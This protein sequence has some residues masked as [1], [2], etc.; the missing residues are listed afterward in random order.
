VNDKRILQ[1]A[2]IGAGWW[3]NEAHLPAL[4]HNPHAEIAAIHS[5]TLDKARRVAHRFECAYAFDSVED[6]LAVPG[7]DA[8]V[9]SS[10]P[11]MHKE[12]ALAALHNRLHVV[13]EKPLTLNSP[14]A[15]LL[16]QEAAERNL[17]L[18]VS[19][20]WQFTRHA[21]ELK[22]RLREG[23]AGPLK[24]GNILMS[25]WM[26]DL[27]D[28]QSGRDIPSHRRFDEKPDPGSYSDPKVCGGGFSFTQLSHALSWFYEITEEAPIGVS[29]Q[30]STDGAPVDLFAS[31]LV[32]L[33]GDGL[34]TVSGVGDPPPSYRPFE[35]RLFHDRCAA[36]LELWKG[37]LAWVGNGEP[38]IDWPELS[39]E[40]RYPKSAPVNTLIDLILNGG[41]NPAPALSSVRA[42]DTI[43]AAIQSSEQGG[44]WIEPPDMNIGNLR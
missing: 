43:V 41:S 23:S 9:I 42:V 39:E 35:I 33:K 38:P 19:C 31:L 21:R 25:N 7:L 8:V 5:C 34:L 2:V 26:R 15:H 29:A 14:D 17:H 13:I 28:P 1:V 3:A 24:S 27:V 20:P 40:E 6:A 18:V 4:R 32:R 10:T 36:A 12:H 44:A 16:M 30:L 11:N 37:Q 22:A